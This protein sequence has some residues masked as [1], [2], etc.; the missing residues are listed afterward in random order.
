MTKNSARVFAGGLCCDHSCHRQ[1]VRAGQSP[2]SDIGGLLRIELARVRV[3]LT[4][5][6]LAL[7]AQ[8]RHAACRPFCWATSDSS[9]VDS[10][11][12]N[13]CATH[14]AWLWACVR[15]NGPL[16]RP[17]LSRHTDLEVR[18]AGIAKLAPTQRPSGEHGT[19]AAAW[20]VARIN[21]AIY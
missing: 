15:E 4:A 13:S 5:R 14:T 16:S 12:P 18:A 9:F 20:H 17:Y 2:V 10:T 21:D 7:V 6:P 19:W 8:R 3:L 1:M 11:Q